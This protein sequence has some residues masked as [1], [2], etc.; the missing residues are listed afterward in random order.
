MPGFKFNTRPELIEALALLCPGACFRSDQNPETGEYDYEHVVWQ[1]PEDS[2]WVPP[3]KEVV[4]AYLT[5]IQNEWD[6]N[7]KYQML[8]KQAYPTIESQ[9]DALWH[10]MDKGVIPKIEP[11]Y[12]EVAAIKDQFPK[13]DAS[14][15]WRGTAIGTLKGAFPDHTLMHNPKIS[16]PETTFP[17]VSPDSIE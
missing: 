4:E 16:L 3:S 1:H 7:V 5:K 11:M 17:Y 13:Y 2:E 6:E 14:L 10:A 15:P 12:S 8:R 9:L